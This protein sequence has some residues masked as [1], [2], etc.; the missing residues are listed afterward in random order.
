MIEQFIKF[1]ENFDLNTQN[2]VQQELFDFSGKS[3]KT[4][5][6]TIEIANV[7]EKIKRYTNEFWTSRQRQAN[8]IHEISYRACFKPQLPR[9]FIE[10][11]TSDY[12]YVYDPFLG[13]GTTILEAGL[14]NRQVMGNDVNPLSRILIE[15]RFLIPN[16]MEL[17]D[18]L[19]D[20]ELD[21]SNKADIDLSMFYHHKT[22]S[23]I[24]SIRNYILEKEKNNQLNALDKWI[25]MVAT[26]RL[27]GHS[28]GF[29]SIYTMP[30]NQAVSPQRQN[31]INKKRKQIP[32]YKDVKKIILKKT[33]S[34][35][36]D[37][38]PIQKSR[39]KN[40]YKTMMLFNDDARETYDIPD[41][42]IKLTVTSPP[43]LSIVQYANDNWLRNWFNNINTGEIQKGITMS[44]S[45]D[46]WTEVMEDVLFELYRITKKGGYVAFEVGE[47]NNGA[48]NLDENIVDVGK[49]A[50][51]TV[52]GI[53]INKQN[54][55][56]TA[57]IWG[58]KNNTKGTNSN[59]IVMFKKI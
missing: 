44:K 14:L 6:E 5:V 13:R 46:E 1:I 9:F 47:I 19:N 41:N 58:I 17:E 34:L 52:F 33:K 23:E 2:N 22:E 48:I 15:P 25:R 12:D 36:K 3:N 20:I 24:V 35:I 32:E 39:L 42:S 10:Q 28:K 4:I 8:R 27:T 40:I 50:G 54:F 7:A 30:P 11:L 49:Y 57:N 31:K 18:Y 55:T 51:F 53:L 16:L 45:I 21:Y 29:F 59:R 38:T 43:F 56:K 26:N 37:I